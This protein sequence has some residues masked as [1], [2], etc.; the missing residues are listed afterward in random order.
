M[1]TPEEAV[2][3]KNLVTEMKTG[4]SSYRYTY[5]TRVMSPDAEGLSFHLGADILVQWPEKTI[6]IYVM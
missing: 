2:F 4:N 3:L 1:E 5:I 6:V